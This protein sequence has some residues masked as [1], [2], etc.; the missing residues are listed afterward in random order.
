MSNTYDMKYAYVVIAAVL[1][2]LCHLLLIVL[3]KHVSFLPA[4]L[5]SP[6]KRPSRI[7]RIIPRSMLKLKPSPRPDKRVVLGDPEL[8]IPSSDEDSPMPPSDSG[9]TAGKGGKSVEDLPIPDIPPPKV[10]VP[11]PPSIVS[12]KGDDLPPERLNFD[13]ILIPEPPKL[14]G[15]D[16][17]L[18]SSG[19]NNDSGSGGGVIELPMPL[20]LPPH[21]KTEDKQ[22]ETDLPITPETTL[23]PPEPVKSMDALMD[24]EVFKY[25]SPRGGGYFRMDITPNKSADSLPTFNKDVVFLLDVSG[26]IGRWRLNEF[27]RGLEEAL[28]FLRPKDR[29]NIVAFKS[30]PYPLF[31]DLVFPTKRNLKLAEAFLFKMRHGGDTNIYSA[32]APYVGAGNKKDA[33]PL[34]L[35]L[36]SDGEVNSG[37]IVQDR[38]LINTVSNDNKRGAGIYCFSCGPDRNSFLMDLLAYRNRGESVNDKEIG[39]SDKMIERFVKAVSDIKVA[40]LEYQLSSDIADKSFPKRLPNLYKGKTL[41]IYGRY[42]SDTMTISGRITGM[43]S[44]GE[45]REIVVSI[46]LDK[47]KSADGRLMRKWAEQ[48]IYHLYSLLTV[49]YDEATKKEIHE[50]AALYRLHLPYLDKHLKPRRKNF[51]D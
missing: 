2:L 25:P 46:P 30:R 17:C 41:S 38:E 11:E 45:R 1:S 14:P 28:K 5:I 20:T 3:F 51:V 50:T 34:I 16:I 42:R 13:R 43:D 47:A 12:I 4:T 24:V 37:A 6:P 40:D 39:G 33:R 18:P 23:L 7:I 31:S 49:K 44:L 9:G 22:P 26:S 48:Y 10:G 29:M 21:K 8:P 35:F 36:L 19:E 27:K 15:N 32:L